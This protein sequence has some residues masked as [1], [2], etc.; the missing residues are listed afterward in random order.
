MGHTMATQLCPC[1]STSGVATAAARVQADCCTPK[2]QRKEPL[3]N[4]P[5]ESLVE[6]AK[7]C[8]SEIDV[9][10]VSV[11]SDSLDHSLSIFH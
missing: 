9:G 11:E 2:P 5:A 1:D 6:L 7:Q 10:L 3:T 4:L 8:L